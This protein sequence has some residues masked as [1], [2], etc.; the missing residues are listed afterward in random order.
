VIAVRPLLGQRVSG[1]HRDLLL[2]K[3]MVGFVLAV[4]VATLIELFLD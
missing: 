2:L 1:V 4:Q 3:W